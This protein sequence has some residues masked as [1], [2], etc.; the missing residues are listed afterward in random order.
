MDIDINDLVA[1]ILDFLTE[2]VEPLAA[3]GF[4]LVIKRVYFLGVK[5]MIFGVIA[6]LV[7]I[8]FVKKCLNCAK[9]YLQH[10]RNEQ[11]DTVFSQDDYENFTIVFGGIGVISFMLCMWNIVNAIDYFINPEWNAIFL[12]LKLMGVD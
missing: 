5:D 10:M 2:I 3:K 9:Y 6:G 4:E 12:I 11:P 1:Q 7:M 8:V